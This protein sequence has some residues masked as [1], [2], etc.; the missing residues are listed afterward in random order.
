V[1]QCICHFMDNFTKTDDSN[2]VCPIAARTKY[3][4]VYKGMIP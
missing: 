3:S 4:W 2:N 1:N